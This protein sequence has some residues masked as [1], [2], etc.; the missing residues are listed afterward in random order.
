MSEM[1]GT[2]RVLEALKEKWSTYDA[3]KQRKIVLT[4]VVTLVVALSVLGYYSSRGNKP[5]TRKT[6]V[7]KQDIS[8][9]TN[10]ME[11][12]LYQETKKLVEDQD[13]KIGDLSKQLEILKKTGV[14]VNPDMQPSPDAPVAGKVLSTEAPTDAPTPG[15]KPITKKATNKDITPPP[16]PPFSSKSGYIPSPPAPWSGKDDYQDSAAAMAPA[17]I[18]NISIVSNKVADQKSEE[19]DSKK[20][21]LSI[22][23]PP[24]ILPATL[25]NGIDAPTIGD[26]KKNPIP[27]IFRIRDMAILPNSIKAAT[28]GCFAIGEGEGSLADERVHIRV[29]SL[30][31]LAKDGNAVIDQQ[32]SG[33]TIDE[34]GKVG[35]RG[36]V[37]AKMGS[38]LARNAL[39]GFFGGVG[40]AMQT[41]STTVQTTASGATN[42]FTDT[43]L[44]NLAR[45]GIG[46]G[47]SEAAKDLQKFYLR[48]AE[49]SLPVI[50]VGGAKPVTIVIKEGVELKIK[51]QSV[52]VKYPTK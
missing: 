50:E 28:R 51:E 18:G 22:Y 19:D 31:C 25:L 14:P 37:V 17:L 46:G 52:E 11:K 7:T 38:A 3:Q 12:G 1:N 13:R 23:L 5:I 35:L 29:V 15:S 10:M 6:E 2:N 26:A 48:L 36:N 44:K 4:A 9:D 43:D 8:L 32:V 21:G 49:S 33:F 39:A 41:A 24:S 34:D 47:I 40:S 42:I 27:V 16:P 20:N 45:S 30:S